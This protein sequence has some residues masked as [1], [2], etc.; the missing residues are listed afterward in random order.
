MFAAI[1]CQV[2]DGGANSFRSSCTI[3]L[4]SFGS[5]S[6]LKRNQ[7]V[8]SSSFG[9]SCD[10]T[11]IE[12]LLD[13]GYKFVMTARFQSDPQERIWAIPPNEWGPVPCFFKGY[14][15]IRENSQNHVADQGG[16]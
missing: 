2:F 6:V 7:N 11:L 16:Y 8:W 15:S 12:D 4:D 3:S 14:R 13:E 9:S 1:S 5:I 10:R